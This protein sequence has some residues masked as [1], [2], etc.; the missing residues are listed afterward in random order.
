MRS[1]PAGDTTDYNQPR[2]DQS[3]GHSTPGQEVKALK[4][5]SA[6]VIPYMVWDQVLARS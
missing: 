5:A 4:L 1:M 6:P 2:P 3:G